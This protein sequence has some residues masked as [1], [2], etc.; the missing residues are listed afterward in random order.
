MTAFLTGFHYLSADSEISS[1]TN[2]LRRPIK[3]MIDVVA[4]VG[5]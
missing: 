5:K 2:I 4:N 3:W 1:D